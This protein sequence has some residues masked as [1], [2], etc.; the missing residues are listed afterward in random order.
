MAHTSPSA[1]L[2]PEPQRVRRGR[3]GSTLAGNW[4]GDLF[5]DTPPPERAP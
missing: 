2:A 4:L 3:R 5:D 1:A